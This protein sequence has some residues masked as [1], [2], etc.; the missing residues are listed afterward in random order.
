LKPFQRNNLIS[1]AFLGCSEEPVLEFILLNRELLLLN[2]P[3]P[4]NDSR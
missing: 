4:V 1:P 2:I 3:A